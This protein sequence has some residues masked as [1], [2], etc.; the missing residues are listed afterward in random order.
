MIHQSLIQIQIAT[1][2]HP[3]KSL[4]LMILVCV[5]MCDVFNRTLGWLRCCN[6]KANSN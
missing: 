6:R 5:S 1:P 3:K 4:F 2:N